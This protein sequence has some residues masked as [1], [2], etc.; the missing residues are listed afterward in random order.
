MKY[1]AQRRRLKRTKERREIKLRVACLK[2]KYTAQIR[3][4]FAEIKEMMK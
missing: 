2:I 3:R 1:T 4:I